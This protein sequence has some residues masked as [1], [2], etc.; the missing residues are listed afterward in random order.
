[1]ADMHSYPN[2]NICSSGMIREQNAQIIVP[3]PWINCEC[4]C[5]ARQSFRSVTDSNDTKY[6]ILPTTVLH[7]D[8]RPLT[9]T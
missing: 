9:G 5:N 7:T 8:N 4:C 2:I 1:M 6:H 3:I